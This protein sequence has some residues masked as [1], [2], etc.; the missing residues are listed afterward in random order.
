MNNGKVNAGREYV[1]L[2]HKE[3]KLRC[4]IVIIVSIIIKLECKFALQTLFGTC[5]AGNA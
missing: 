5:I 2:C 3:F 1:W 4:A